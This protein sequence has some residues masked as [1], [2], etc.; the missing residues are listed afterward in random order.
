[1]NAGDVDLRLEGSF[2]IVK[3]GGYVELRLNLGATVKQLASL[4]KNPFDDFVA[5]LILKA[6]A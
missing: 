5:D 3:Y 1:M 6:T 4:T 2:L